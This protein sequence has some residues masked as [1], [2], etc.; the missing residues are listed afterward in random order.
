MNFLDPPTH[1]EFLKLR[2]DIGS[3]RNELSPR[4]AELIERFG[5]WYRALARGVILPTTDAQRRFVDV[6][7]ER[8]EVVSEHERA[9]MAYRSVLRAKMATS[10]PESQPNFELGEE[11]AH[12]LSWAAGQRDMQGD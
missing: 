6:H 12:G 1:S 3:I 7:H 9:W 5:A 8:A 2:S 4:E 11:K 10:D